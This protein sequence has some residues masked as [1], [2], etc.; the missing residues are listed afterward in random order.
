[1]PDFYDLVKQVNDAKDASDAANKVLASAKQNLMLAM[2]QSDLKIV[3]TEIGKVT[4]CNGKRT[5][6]VTCKALASEIKLMQERG[7]RTGRATESIGSPY[8]MIR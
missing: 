1:M 6:K 7:V 8:I 3:E 2:Q 4:L 5:V